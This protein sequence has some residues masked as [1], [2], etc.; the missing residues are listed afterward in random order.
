MSTLEQFLKKIYFKPSSPVAFGGAKKLYDYVKSKGYNPTFKYI[1]EWLQDQETYSLYKPSRSKFQRLRVVTKGPRDVYDADLADMADLSEDNDGVKFLLVVI[2]DFTRRLTVRVLPNKTAKAVKEALVDAFEEAQKP[3]VLRTDAGK[4]FLN[5]T[6]K[7]YLQGE[8]VYHQVSRN[9]LI[10]ANY[11]ERVIGTLKSKIW[12]YLSHNNTHRYVDK[13][14][15]LV[16]GYNNTKHSTLGMK[17][18]EVTDEVAK[19]LWWK[20]Y[21][22]K[23]IKKKKPFT[24]R[25]GDTVRVSYLKNK[26][27]RL[28]DQQYSG[29]IFTVYKRY[30]LRGMPFYELKDYNGEKIEGR[31][32]AQEM[33]KVNIDPEQL[34]KVE[35]VIKTRKRAGKVQFLAK[36][37]H[38]PDRFNAWVD[39]V[40]SL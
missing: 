28:Y 21:R 15:Q 29:E 25:V 5:N 13:L 30:R 4:E 34:W 3:Q 14:Q 20:L 37:M 31:F 32:Y 10:K 17:P 9:A 19:T 7:D 18:S 38:W 33:Q 2:D 40:E 8:N 24:F 12:R 11:A 22:P 16:K 26:F 36:F 1:R 23:K 35:K 27:T 39:D 6:L